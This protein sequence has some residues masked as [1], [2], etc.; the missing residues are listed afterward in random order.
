[1]GK[2]GFKSG[3][4]EFQN[5]Q[6]GTATIADTTDTVSVSFDESMKNVPAIAATPEKEQTVWISSKT[7][8]G[9]TLNQHSGS[10]GTELTIHWIAMDD[11][12]V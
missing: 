8:T 1:M 2:Y 6:S 10:S 5:I 7:T 11:Q 4:G 12:D 3:Y 9:F